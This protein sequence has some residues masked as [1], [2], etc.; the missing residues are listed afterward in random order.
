[1]FLKASTLL[2]LPALIV[3]G[4][5]VKQKTPRLPEPDGE[6]CGIYGQGRPTLSLLIL[7]DSAAAGVGVVTQADALLGQ[8]L[9][10]LSPYFIIEYCLRL[11]MYGM[12]QYG[13]CRCSDCD[14]HFPGN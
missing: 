8:L 3:Q 14:C 7:G 6:R 9:T 1:M 12:V 4:Y 10:L 11:C 2:L 5:I 13:R